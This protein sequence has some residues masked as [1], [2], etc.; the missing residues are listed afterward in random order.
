LEEQPP[1]DDKLNIYPDKKLGSMNPAIVCLRF[2][3]G[4]P[5]IWKAENA[6]K[7]AHTP[8]EK[9]APSPVDVRFWV[10]T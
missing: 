3:P 7:L 8:Q 9:S 10:T 5:S 4:S 6:D 1:V 2:L